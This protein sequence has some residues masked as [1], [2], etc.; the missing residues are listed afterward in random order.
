MT[1]PRAPSTAKRNDARAVRAALTEVLSEAVSELRLSAIHERV[2]QRL[3]STLSRTRFKG[4]V[5][6]QSKGARPLLERLGYGRY[7][8]RSESSLG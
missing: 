5:N 1:S 6:D 7:R 2:E 4:Y 3:G 8:L